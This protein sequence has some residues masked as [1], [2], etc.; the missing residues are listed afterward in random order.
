M[1]P[2]GGI[3]H[4]THV[5]MHLSDRELSG[6]CAALADVLEGP[7]DRPALLA[8]I[9]AIGVILPHHAAFC[10][11]NSREAQPIYLCDSFV[12]PVAKQAVQRYV[13]GTYVINPA[14]N[15]YLE[16]LPTG[17]YR[18]RDLAPDR[19]SAAR[20]PALEIVPEDDEEIGFRTWDWPAGME[21]LV[22]A[23]DLPDGRMGEIS[24]SQ[25]RQI[26]FSD[27]AIA[28]LRPFL[29]LIAAAFRRCWAAIGP[30]LAPSGRKATRLDA[31][32]RELLSGREATILQMVLK[33]H[34]S[35][36]IALNLG[37]ALATVKTHRQNAYAKLGI[38]TQQELFAAFLDHVRVDLA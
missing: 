10:V 23:I 30:E 21:E 2:A 33:G 7:G 27:A 14:Y 3:G 36:S 9:A 13:G 11:V 35:R 37:I 17:L 16:G 20:E 18:M 28:S 5:D 4:G 29:P 22:L 38:A 25:T 34:S 26:G 12:A 8:I 15:A 6:F 31:F 1:R 19:W 32:G 24:F